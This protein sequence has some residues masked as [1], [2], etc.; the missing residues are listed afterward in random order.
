[1][2]VEIQ[3]SL[4]TDFDNDFH[5]LFRAKHRTFRQEIEC[6]TAYWHSS[7]ESC[8]HCVTTRDRQV[9]AAIL[10]VV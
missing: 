1:M 2:Y 10:H 5:V 7:V 6:S 9:H 3:R 4:A 8:E